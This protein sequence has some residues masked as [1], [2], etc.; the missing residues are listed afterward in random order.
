[1]GI[2]QHLKDMRRCELIY[3]YVDSLFNPKDTII[4]L[5]EQILNLIMI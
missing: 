5:V 2:K 4:G 3:T 1:M